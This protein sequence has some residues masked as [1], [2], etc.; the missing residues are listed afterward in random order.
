M[1]ITKTTSLRRVE[2]FPVSDTDAP[3]AENAG[4]PSLIVTYAD[5][6]DD[7]DDNDLPAVITRESRL[8]RY[9]DETTQTATDVTGEAQ[10]VQDICAA[11]WT[12]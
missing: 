9:S 5:V 6:I 4:N 3:I 11:V 1:A 12:D 7:P 2:I 8:I 10:L